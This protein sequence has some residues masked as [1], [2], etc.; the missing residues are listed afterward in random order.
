MEQDL[1]TADRLMPGCAGQ[2]VALLDQGPLRL[3][4]TEL[5]LIPGAVLLRRYT[6]PAGSPIAFD[7][8]GVLLALRRKDAARIAVREVDVPWTA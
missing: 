2:I 4:L 3:R 6:A 7:V 8:G 5:G 1:L